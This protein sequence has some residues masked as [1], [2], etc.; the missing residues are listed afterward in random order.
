MINDTED[1]VLQGGSRRSLEGLRRWRSKFSG[2]RRRDVY[3][4]T[5]GANWAFDQDAK[6]ITKGLN[7]IAGVSSHVTRDPWELKNQIIQFGDRYNFFSGPYDTLDSSNAVF[8]TWFHGGR[9]D[10]D[11]NIRRLCEK[12]PSGARHTRMIVVPCE[13]TRQDLVELGISESKIAKIPLGVDLD[14][15]RP[16]SNRSR[17]DMRAR[18]GIP[19][20]AVCLGSFQKDGVGWDDGLEPKR[21]KGPDVLLEMIA[22][23]RPR[24]QNLFVLLT[25]PAR[26]YV[27][28]GLDKLGVPYVHRFLTNYDD[29]VTYYYSLD[30]YVIASRCEGGPKSLLESWAT[31]VPV[32]STRVGMAADLLTQGKNGLLTE[33]EDAAGLANHAMELIED[34]D[35]RHAIC[36]QALED[37]EDYDWRLIANRYYSELYRPLL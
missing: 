19:E 11:P 13:T 14:L 4:V 35:T 12:L 9:G 30:L 21:I 31:S 16:P 10:T 20:G 23:L 26:G 27:K 17:D 8:L 7:N 3:Y 1:G 2:A 5:D 15:F 25:G 34:S 32:V 28:S 36:R 22:T 37:V 29:I 33:I 18:L 24:Y 6:Y